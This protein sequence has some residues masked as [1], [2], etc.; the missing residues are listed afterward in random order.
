MHLIYKWP[1]S[2]LSRQNTM[3]TFTY[4]IMCTSLQIAVALHH[5]VRCLLT[6][7]NLLLLRLL[8][9]QAVSKQGIIV[10]TGMMTMCKSHVHKA[11]LLIKI[12]LPFF[13]SFFFCFMNV[14]QIFYIY[15]YFALTACSSSKKCTKPV[16][17]SIY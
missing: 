10:I 16:F 4:Y 17:Y 8:K 5:S 2:I 1:I 14:I 11:W 9:Q 3:P 12:Y 15:N 6:Y 7:W 13:C